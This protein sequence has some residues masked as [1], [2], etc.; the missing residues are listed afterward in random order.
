M[1]KAEMVEHIAAENELS[2][3]A[4]AK[5]LDTMVGIIHTDLK[6][7][8]RCSITNLGT[9]TVTKRAARTGRN[10]ATGEALKIKASNNTKFKA[11]PALKEV[12]AKFKVK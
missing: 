1:N 2:K 9:F 6:K 10:P 4:A 12:I 7:T 8:G 11:A 5:V 3:A